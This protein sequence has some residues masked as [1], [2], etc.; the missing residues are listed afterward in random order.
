MF[1]SLFSK[2]IIGFHDHVIPAIDK[3]LNGENAVRSDDFGANI[4]GDEKTDSSYF[5]DRRTISLQMEYDSERY[6]YNLG[7]KQDSEIFKNRIRDVLRKTMLN[8]SEYYGVIQGLDSSVVEED[9]KYG[10]ASEKNKRLVVSS[11]D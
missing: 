1:D 4:Y 10:D 11:G 9:K 3:K 7:Y 2:V 8:S 6:L 5:A